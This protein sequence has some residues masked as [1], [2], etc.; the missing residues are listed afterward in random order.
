M[1]DGDYYSILGV[2]RNATD[3]EIKKA[4]RKLAAK[5]HPDKAGDDPEAMAK[6]KE[7]S[8]AYQVLSDGQKK[9][10]YDKYGK[11]GLK[12][13]GMGGMGGFGG[14]ADLF[15]M[16]GGGFGGMGGGRRAGPR[17]GEDI[18]HRLAVTLDDLY[19]GRSSKMAVT[20]DILCPDCHGSG[21]L[22]GKSVT[23]SDC[24]GRGV[25][26]VHRQ[27]GPG[28]IQQMQQQCS[29]C[30]GTGQAVPASDRCK[31]CKGHRT[32]KDKKVLDVT[33]EKGMSNGKKIVFPGEGQAEPEGEPGD[34]VFVVAEKEHPTFKRQGQHLFIE[35]TIPL[36]SALTGVSFHITHMDG[37]KLLV[38]T[39][40][41]QIITPEMVLCVDGEGMPV[42]RRP[43]EKG[44]L[45]IKFDVQ[46]PNRLDATQTGLL[47]KLLPCSPME[48]EKADDETI[49]MTP[50]DQSKLR[51]TMAGGNAYDSDEDMG[52][53]GAP[54]MQCQSQ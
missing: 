31:K 36:G 42:Y 6:F 3:A 38:Q 39:H 30:N 54:G 28:M 34:I 20:R 13:D 29:N 45:F 27:I 26:I 4:Y 5:Y 10:I 50:F 40:P 52:H 43:F 14:M 51:E 11:E 25:K 24:H 19:K 49:T 2:G 44:N 17:K 8:E 46:F 12:N 35:K 33:I 23:C 32:V 15:D 47:K 18:V 53:G 7:M 48:T 37:R 1:A 16:M 9:D 22:S 41:G 21:S